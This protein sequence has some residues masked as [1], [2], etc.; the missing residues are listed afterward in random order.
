MTTSY[1]LDVYEINVS[2][3]KNVNLMCLNLICIKGWGVF[4]ETP[5]R[6]GLGLFTPDGSNR[7]HND[8]G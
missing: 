5:P 1:T 4:P 6:A 7:T 2:Q 8:P 3:W